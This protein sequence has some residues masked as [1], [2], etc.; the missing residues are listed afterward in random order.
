M[1]SNTEISVDR[2]AT[3]GLAGHLGFNLENSRGL[4][5]PYLAITGNGSMKDK[6]K[7]EHAW[8]YLVCLLS[9]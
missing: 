6:I 1:A 2:H 5:A 9:E 3:H 8:M 4:A 7:E